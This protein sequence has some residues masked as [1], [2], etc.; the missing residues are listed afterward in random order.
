MKL[1]YVAG[2]YRGITDDEVYE[3]IQTARRRAKNYWQRGFAVFCPHLNTSFFSG[4]VDETQFTDAG[5]LF[6]AKCDVIALPLNWE[7]SR[8]TVDEAIYAEKLG[9]EFIKENE[10]Q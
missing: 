2:P 5:L 7:L 9:L 8:G 1:L 4:V 10:L 6:L 3:N